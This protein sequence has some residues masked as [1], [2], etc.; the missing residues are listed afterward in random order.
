MGTVNYGAEDHHVNMPRNFPPEILLYNG[1]KPVSY[2]AKNS[3]YFIAIQN[4]KTVT[5]IL[6]VLSVQQDH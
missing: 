1:L 5:H 6:R 4:G 3:R 2:K